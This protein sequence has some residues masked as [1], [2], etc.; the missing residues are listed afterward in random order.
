MIG[1]EHYGYTGTITGVLSDGSSLECTFGIMN[2]ENGVSNAN[3]YLIPEPCS[4]VLL[5]LGVLRRRGL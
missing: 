3:I 4:L 5:G 2:D 1:S